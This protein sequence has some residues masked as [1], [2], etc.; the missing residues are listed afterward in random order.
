M[1]E[2]D[3]SAAGVPI[4]ENLRAAHRDFL[5]HVRSPGT[6]WTGAAR[7]AIA[8]ES[9]SALAC[10]LCRERKAALSPNQ[11][12]GEHASSGPLDAAVVEVIHRVRTDPA[13]LS[14]SWLD[15][16]LASGLREEEYV[17]VVALVTMMAGIDQ[18]ARALGIAPFPL[19]E[20]LPGEPSRHRPI[21][22]KP[23]ISWLS[24]LAP[25]DAEGPDADVYGGAPFVPN[26]VRA[27]SVVPA[28]V[29]MLRRESDAH[30]VPM[31]KLGDA[32]YGL[33]LDRMQIE[34]VA[35][36]VSALNECFY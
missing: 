3:Y 25:E 10:E 7:V 15:G 13:R 34:L 35:G 26:I 8:A 6:W 31:G 1:S 4:R 21:G 5:E 2:L 30:Y 9:R 11:V 12:Q 28:E 20:P 29:R 22:A 23:G 32:A 36:R 14:R 33:D 24:M 18:F 17:E 19:P 16:I 27:L